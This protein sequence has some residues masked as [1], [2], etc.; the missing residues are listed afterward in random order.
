MNLKPLLLTFQLLC[1]GDAVSTHVILD[2]GGHEIIFP[3]Q[4]P[5]AIDGLVAG[6]AVAVSYVFSKTDTRHPK[7]TRVALGGLIAV[8]VF[9][10]IHNSIAVHQALH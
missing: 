6:Q 9:A 5:W 3:T 2:H 4:N 8:R 1:V 10:V 7:L